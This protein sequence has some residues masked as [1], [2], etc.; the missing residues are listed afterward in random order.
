MGLMR[1][2]IRLI[3]MDW[4][5]VH[6]PNFPSR[7]KR[8]VR[9]MGMMME[10]VEVEGIIVCRFHRETWLS[11]HWNWESWGSIKSDLL[12]SGTKL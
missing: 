10:N 5:P 6:I 9:P 4:V 11:I 3:S 2:G 1:D 7:A 8:E 12:E